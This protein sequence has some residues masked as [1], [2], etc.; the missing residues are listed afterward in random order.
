M[1][2][3]Q[4][5]RSPSV[6]FEEVLSSPVNW[7]VQAGLRGLQEEKVLPW[8]SRCFGE[9]T[10]VRLAGVVLELEECKKILQVGGLAGSAL[11]PSQDVQFA[12]INMAVLWRRCTSGRMGQERWQLRF[13]WHVL[14]H[15]CAGNIFTGSGR[16]A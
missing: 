12:L 2:V 1:F 4:N 14:Q 9:E 5:L 6:L 16:C 11:K 3:R 7:I 15:L 13:C 8:E 10:R